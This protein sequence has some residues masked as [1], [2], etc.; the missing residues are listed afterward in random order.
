MLRVPAESESQYL[1][2]VTRQGVIKRCEVAEFDRVNKN[3]KIAIDLDEGDEL[4][5][6]RLTSGSDELIVATANGMANRFSEDDVRCMG[7]SARGVKAITLEDGDVVVG[8]LKVDPDRYVLTVTEQGKGYLASIEDYSLHRRGGK[9]LTN[10]HVSEESG[11]VVTVRSVS[12]DED[13]MLIADDGV[14]IRVPAGDIR[15]CRRPAGG[16][17]VMRPNAGAKVTAMAV[18]PRVAEEAA[19]AVEEESGEAE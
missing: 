8:M 2:M 15:I 9:G 18:T 17:W 5:W 10:Y 16:V 11:S 14:I 13:V 12:L 1:C 7:R 6:V 4:A 19:E 3:G